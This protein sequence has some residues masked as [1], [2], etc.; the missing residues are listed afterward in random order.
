MRG[1]YLGDVHI[2]PEPAKIS[3]S[4]GGLL[5]RTGRGRG[6]IININGVG[7]TLLFETYY[8]YVRITKI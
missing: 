4:R 7:M 3:T 8:L 5:H 1:E 2:G 6:N